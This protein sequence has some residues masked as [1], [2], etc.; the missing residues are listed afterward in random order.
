[1]SD[2]LTI[3]SQTFISSKRASEL[4][5]Y[6]QDYIGQL[7]RGGSITARR[8]GGLW[9]VSEESLMSYKKGAAQYKPE[10]PLNTGEIARP[11]SLVSFDGRGYISTSRAAKITGYTPDY[12]G[13]MA[14]AGIIPSRQVGNRWYVEQSGILRHKES[15]D[16][17]L[18]AVQ[19]Q[20]VGITNQKAT[21]VESD[22]AVAPLLKYVSDNRELLP[23]MGESADRLQVPT[24]DRSA[25][26]QA[27]QQTSWLGLPMPTPSAFVARPAD[28]RSP[29]AEMA[30]E[31]VAEQEHVIP[32]RIH[33]NSRN[34]AKNKAFF[35]P[36][37][38]IPRKS[39][40][41]MLLPVGMFTI[42]IVLSLGFVSLKR[43]STYTSRGTAQLASVGMNFVGKVGDSLENWFIPEIVYQRTN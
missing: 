42:V 23:S 6:E 31:E 33:H 1:M 39:L 38:V 35:K 15:K 24:I 41:P 32:I 18:A 28:I 22:M 14:R 5:G 7:C 12:V 21:E 27:N 3:D 19:V 25:R 40:L 2:E 34:I 30:N 37:A 9:Y 29:E 36:V 43:S 11:D 4:S 13:Q 16:A 8:V 17:L 20:S 26:L 10:P